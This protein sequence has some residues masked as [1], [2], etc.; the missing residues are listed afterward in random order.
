[1]R[2]VRVNLPLALMLGLAGST[3]AFLQSVRPTHLMVPAHKYQ[4][5]VSRTRA[6]PRAALRSMRIMSAAVETDADEVA[7]PE[8]AAE[9]SPAAAVE[10]EIPEPA[11]D[12]ADDAVADLEV[13]VLNNSLDDRGWCFH[14]VLC[15]GCLD[16]ARAGLPQ[17]WRRDFGRAPML[18]LSFATC[19]VAPTGV[20]GWSRGYLEAAVCDKSRLRGKKA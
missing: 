15:R 7:S 12:V 20:C 8:L 1:M 11:A 5:A 4:A 16:Q 9:V 10:L 3:S 17:Q 19:H 13:G 2:S 14:V 6:Q 18:F